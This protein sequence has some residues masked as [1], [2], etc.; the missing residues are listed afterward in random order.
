MKPQRWHYPTIKGKK[1]DPKHEFCLGC[2]KGIINKGG[3]AKPPER[4]L[5]TLLKE[6][7]MEN[8]FTRLMQLQQCLANQNRLKTDTFQLIRTTVD[9]QHKPNMYENIVNSCSLT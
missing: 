2:C 7:M 8:T 4:S 1:I 3:P 9:T 5:T 6:T